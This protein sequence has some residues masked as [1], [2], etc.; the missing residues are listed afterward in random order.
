[1]TIGGVI[2]DQS[3]REIAEQF[4]GRA[5]EHDADASFPF[6]NFSELRERDLLGL[7]IPLH[8]GGGEADLA[9]VRRV[10]ES[11]AKRMS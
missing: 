6:E 10:V 1:M 3:L 11:V 7:T 9:A 4:H 2:S 5:A 8:L